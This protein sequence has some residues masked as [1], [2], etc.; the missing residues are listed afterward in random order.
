MHC[1]S[2]ISLNLRS[3]AIDRDRSLRY[4]PSDYFETFPFS[5]HLEIRPAFKAA[6][7]AYYDFHAALMVRNG[8]GMTKTYNRAST[9]PMRTTSTSPSSGSS[10]PLWTALSSLPMAGATSRLTANSSSTTRSTKHLGRE[11]EILPLPPAR[12]RPATKSSPA[13]WN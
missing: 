6:G 9:T 7:K 4:T 8:E 5:E 1:F 13:S 11:E 3:G 10:T 2:A 12:P